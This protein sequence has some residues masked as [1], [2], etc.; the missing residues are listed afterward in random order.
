MISDL[1]INTDMETISRRE[2]KD[3][4]LNRLK[5]QLERCYKNSAFY[6]DKFKAAGVAP[7]DIRSLDDLAK[8]PLTRKEELRKEQA[9][10]KP[11][12]RF[13]IEGSESWRELHPSTGTTGNPVYTLWTENDVKN[14]TDFTARTMWSVGIRPGYVVQNAFSYG[15][16]IAGLSVHYAAAKIGCLIIPIGATMTKRQ[17]DFMVELGSNAFLSTPSYALYISE[18]MREEGVSPDNLKLELGLFG[19]EPGAE[20]P[21][22]RKRIEEGLGIEAYDYYGLTEIAPTMAS[23]CTE[24]EGLHWCEDHHLVEVVDPDTLERCGPGEEGVLV[25]TDLTKEAVPMIRYWSNDI[26]SLDLDRCTCGRTHVRSPRGITG[27]ADDM[28]IYK[29]AKFYPTQVEKIIRGLRGLSSEF[30]IELSLDE[31]DLTQYTVVAEYVDEAA[32]LQELRARLEQALKEELNVTPNVRLVKKGEMERTMFKA[33]R[34][35]DKRML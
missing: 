22:T 11:F 17:I 1:Y 15:L 16:W 31:K 9:A 13:V 5:W 23:E 12:G 24:K 7:H 20:I 21:P 8:V 14:I 35:I 6:R 3:L 32:D 2:L 30:H 29:G 34:I 33:R 10:H 18:R 27:R 19:G 4:Q 25:F 28:L 26:A